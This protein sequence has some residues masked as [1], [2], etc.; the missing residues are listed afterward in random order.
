MKC[1][2]NHIIISLHN[3]HWG[4][5]IYEAFVYPRRVSS[6]PETIFQQL[7]EPPRHF[8]IVVNPK[9]F[10]FIDYMVIRWHQIRR[11]EWSYHNVPSKWNKHVLNEPA[12]YRVWRCH[13]RVNSPHYIFEFF[14]STSSMSRIMPQHWWWSVGA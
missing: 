9:T 2:T 12:R 4:Q 8:Q 10:W 6:I 3:C 13:E 1:T 5:Y 7:S 14:Y 11:V